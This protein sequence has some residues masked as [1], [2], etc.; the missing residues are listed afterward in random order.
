MEKIKNAG[1]RTWQECLCRQGEK[2]KESCVG[3]YDSKGIPRLVK[4]Q[5]ATE[6]QWGFNGKIGFFEG[7]PS[8]KKMP[9]TI[10]PKES[11]E[12]SQ[13]S[14]LTADASVAGQTVQQALPKSQTEFQLWIASNADKYATLSEAMGAMMGEF[15]DLTTGHLNFEPSNDSNNTT[16]TPDS[17]INNTQHQE[18]NNYDGSAPVR[19][20]YE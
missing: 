17:S 18:I 13:V 4:Q 5:V 12:L 6:E 9:N 2:V 19:K 16:V 11:P 3:G 14:D 20:K 7:H 8:L 15:A 10:V 1:K